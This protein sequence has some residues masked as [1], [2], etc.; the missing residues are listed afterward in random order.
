MIFKHFL[1]PDYL[2]TFQCAMCAECC[3]LRWNIYFDPASVKKYHGFAAADEDFAALLKSGIAEKKD[4]G[5][6]VQFRQGEQ[7]TGA[8]AG[9]EKNVCPFLNIEGLCAIQ[10]QY[11]VEALSDTCKIFPREITLTERGCEMALSYACPAAAATLKKREPIQFYQNPAGFNF[12]PINMQYGKIGNLMERQKVGK[13]N[14]FEVEE[15]LIDIM[16][17]RGLDID[18]RL[19]L[20]GMIVDKLK[21]GDL[22]GVRRYLRNIDESL[23]SQF[24]K[25]SAN[26]IFMLRFIKDV[27]DGIAGEERP[28]DMQKLLKLAHQQLKLLNEKVISDK[29]AKQVAEGYRQYYE[30][31]LNEINHIYEN[32]FV[33]F[34]FAKLFYTHKYLDAYFLMVFFYTLI[35]F[36]TVCTC[37]AEERQADEDMVVAVIHTI[38]RG[39]GHNK[40]FYE[41]ILK[42]IK[43]TNYHRLPYM[44][45]LINHP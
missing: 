31:S 27:M 16:Q 25:L 34:I 9:C 37:M 38:A 14:Y 11:G 30:P 10:K 21:D 28:G 36:F 43:Q 26:P 32:Y 17:L 45:S 29:M 44:I 6:F 2:L 18:I 23:I 20:T 1:V 5:A 8:E 4:G 19:I 35:R 42:Q 7:S 39:I 22:D 15:L 24:Q 41:D 33:N 12:F 40:S 13:T 3:K